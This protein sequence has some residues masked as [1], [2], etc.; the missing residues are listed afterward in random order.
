VLSTRYNSNLA[1]NAFCQIAVVLLR[2][3]FGAKQQKPSYSSIRKGT[4]KISNII[5]YLNRT[6]SA[7]KPWPLV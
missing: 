5:I 7:V 1:S 4:T 6:R 2:W 3:R